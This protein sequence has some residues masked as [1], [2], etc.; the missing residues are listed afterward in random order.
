MCNPLPSTTSKISWYYRSFIISSW[1]AHKAEHTVI[2]FARE[3]PRERKR[4]TG[5]SEMANM[6]A[7]FRSKQTHSYYAVTKVLAQASH[8]S[9]KTRKNDFHIREVPDNASAARRY[10]THKYRRRWNR[11]GERNLQK[12]TLQKSQML[13]FQLSWK[14]LDILATYL[15]FTEVPLQWYTVSEHSDAGHV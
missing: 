9:D 4:E 13:T 6:S 15:F 3:T 14:S 11:G 12:H 7:G 1:H 8:V 10:F 2:N 5:M